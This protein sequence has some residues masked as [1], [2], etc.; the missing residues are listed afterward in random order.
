M[1]FPSPKNVIML[2]KEIKLQVIM[3]PLKRPHKFML[4]VY[5]E[6]IFLSLNL[7]SLILK[8]MMVNFLIIFIGNSSKVPY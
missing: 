3:V 5:H 4:K 8:Y 2:S 7:I 1:V 6:V